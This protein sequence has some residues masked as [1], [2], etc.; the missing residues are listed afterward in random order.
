[1][2]FFGGI[3]WANFFWR[4]FWGNFLGGVYRRIF[5]EDF[6]GGTFFLGG[7]LCILLNSANIFESER[8]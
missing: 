2:E 6:I 3:L 7:I 5:W 4:I 8:D 1:V